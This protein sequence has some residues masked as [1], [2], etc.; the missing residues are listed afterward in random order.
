MSRAVLPLALYFVFLGV[1][2]LVNALWG[3]A[4][5]SYVW[6]IRGVSAGILVVCAIILLRERKESSSQEQKSEE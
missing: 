5:D 6:C 2:Q 4:L 1:W 3:G